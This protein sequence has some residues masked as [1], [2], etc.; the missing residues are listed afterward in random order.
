MPGEE[1]LASG[2]THVRVATTSAH[3]ALG[4]S[5]Q[6]VSMALPHLS[7]SQEG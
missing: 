1:L 4:C 6:A 2:K 3:L 7:A 5:A